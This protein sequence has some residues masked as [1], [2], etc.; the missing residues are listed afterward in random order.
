HL[1]N[2]GKKK[3]K[4][5]KDPCDEGEKKCPYDEGIAYRKFKR[6]EERNFKETMQKRIAVDKKLD[7]EWKKAKKRFKK[8]P[9]KD[10]FTCAFVL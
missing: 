4:V 10:T 2:V 7:E 5:E 3:I 1:K 9:M 8:P 6:A